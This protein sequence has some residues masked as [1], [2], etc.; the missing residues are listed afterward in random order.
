VKQNKNNKLEPFLTTKL[1]SFIFG[2]PDAKVDEVLMFC[3]QEIRGV[4]EF[5]SGHKNIVL[6]ERGAG[7]SALF[8]LVAEGKYKFDAD[9][10]EKP[11]KQLIVAID[12]DLDYLAISNVIEARFIDRTK[13]PHGKFRFL[14]E[15]YILSRVI[16]KL[17]DEYGWNAEI[18]TLQEDFGE[19]LGV[20]KEQKFRI[21][22]LLTLYKFSAGVKTDQSGSVTPTISVEPAKDAQNKSIEITDHKIAS[23]R[24]RV[25]K[26]IRSQRAVVIV[27]IDKIDDFVVDLDYQEQKKS[28]QALLE[29]T[30]ALRLPELK[31]KI[32]LRS[33]LYK[34]LDFEKGGY[35]KISTQVVRLEWR[36]DDICEFVARRLL[37][38]YERLNIKTPKWGISSESLDLDPSLREQARDLVGKKITT[39]AGLLELG[40]KAVVLASKMKWSL[41][42]KASHSER[43]TN[44]MDEVFLKVIT[45]IFPSKA[46]HLTLL[47]KREDVPFKSFL[48]DHFKL[49][50]ETPNPR[51]VLM[52]LNYVFDE[53]K[54]YYAKNPDPA[55]REIEPNEL[56]EYEVI[57]KEHFQRGYQKL[58]ITTR[59]TV[60]QLNKNWRSAI[61]RFF[62]AIGNPK[63]N[64]NISTNQLKKLTGWDESEDEFIRFV[65][66]FTHVGLLVPENESARFDDRTF[67]L[68]TVMRICNC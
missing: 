3:P 56:N 4:R 61:G 8:K 66:F 48:T 1:D 59:E 53:A 41:F 60:K 62:E 21:K 5:L 42:W 35:D 45:F 63:T 20:P 26:S 54:E 38:N 51:L 10:S 30:Q 23:F 43:K 33:D 64:L 50:G 68:P 49:G 14:W 34:R 36:A 58:Q 24:E 29:C 13:R 15:I 31:L 44:L 18:Q 52:F 39:L 19:V 11:R 47:C 55:C 57:L 12:D 2:D 16:E 27:L 37:Y 25:R 7:K 32:F 9:T 6:G 46:T 28:V 65:A 67:S 40:L 22:D 17:A